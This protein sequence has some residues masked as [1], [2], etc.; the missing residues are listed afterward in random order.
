MIRLLRFFK[1]HLVEVFL[2]ILMGVATITAGIG[3]LGTSAYLI[4]AAA[5]HPSIAELQ[6]AI[7]GVRFFGISR[8]AFRYAERLVSHSL[9]LRL[10]SSLRV[11]FYRQLLQV[12]QDELS[13]YRSGDLLDRILR[14]LE[15]MEN[16]YVRVFSPFV[17]FLVVT[18]GVSLFV[19][20]FDAKLGWLLAGGLLITGFLLPML[21]VFLN[22]RTA[23]ETVRHSS[24]LSATLVETLAG[25][26]DLQAFGTSQAQ[27]ERATRINKLVNQAQLQTSMLGGVNNG[28][29]LILM[30]VTV[31]ALIWYSIP[32]IQAGF[33]TGI[34]LAVIVLVAMASFEATQVL[35]SAA[36]RLTESVSSAGRLFQIA[37][38]ST[39]N[40]DDLLHPIS[41]DS[42]HLRLEDV[43]F[44]RG[45]GSDFSLEHISFD[46]VKGKKI[47][48]VGPSGGG[49]SSLVE[50]LLKF[51]IPD[52]GRIDL[53]GVDIQTLDNESLR[54]QFSVLAQDA[55]LFNCSLRENLFLAKPGAADKLLY[56]V[57]YRVGLEGWLVALPHGLD[58]WLGDR[59]TMVSGG[60][61][62]RIMIARLLLQDRPFLILDEPMVNLDAPIRR[63]LIKMILTEFPRAGLLW[64]S[65]EY[66]FMKSMDEIL[67]IEHGAIIERGDHNSL[68]AINGKYSTVYC[69]QQN[70]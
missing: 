55:Y 69:T 70:D 65:H 36:Q 46:L 48:I 64:I 52:N 12:K 26:E 49:K 51:N 67:Y 23:R 30:N 3:L 62:Q 5:L 38:Q 61:L 41:T 20:K 53:D 33:F 19:G 10:V 31:L 21:S 58:T 39:A 4:A 57:L 6:V 9:N 54:S 16:L 59:G 44:Q 56:N 45:G 47:A 24:D 63:E 50:L 1:P 25:L 28:L 2:S 8:A 40:Q 29:V 13:I 7:V 66:S 34:S 18:T 14:D 11:W 32:L 35:P 43:N 27:M 22:R 60:E 37:N 42:I 68:L 17:V 15:T